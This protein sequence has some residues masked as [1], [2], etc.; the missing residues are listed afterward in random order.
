ML[1]KKKKGEQE[2]ICLL[3]LHLKEYFII[4]IRIF[5]HF[6]QCLIIAGNE[7]NNVQPNH[8]PIV[9]HSPD[10]LLGTP[11]KYW[12]ESPFTFR[13]ALILC[14]IDITRWHSS[15]ILVHNDMIASHSCYTSVGA[16]GLKIWQENSFHIIT[17]LPAWAVD[18]R[19]DG[20]MLSWFFMLQQKSSLIWRLQCFSNILV[21]STGESQ[22]PAL[23]ILF[24]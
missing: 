8:I 20:S 4:T 6:N 21:S 18:T 2:H 9:L 13:T 24:I 5:W 16:K 14:A 3:F 1:S 15:E 7:N 19:Q 22:F 23:F 12:F 10:S 11:C 17:P